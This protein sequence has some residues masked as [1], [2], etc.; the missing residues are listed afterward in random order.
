M[1]QHQHERK[2]ELEIVPIRATF[3]K[4]R[5][6]K[7]GVATKAKGETSSEFS[8]FSWRWNYNVI[9]KVIIYNNSKSKLMSYHFM[10]SMELY[11]Q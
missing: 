11:G 4:T 1:K 10:Q 9:C 2:L 3:G 5:R 6:H 7:S 8:S